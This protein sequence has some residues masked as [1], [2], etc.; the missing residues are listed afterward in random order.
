MSRHANQ[1]SP[2]PGAGGVVVRA[3]LLS[4]FGGAAPATASIAPLASL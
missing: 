1:R 4:W 2:R 3:S